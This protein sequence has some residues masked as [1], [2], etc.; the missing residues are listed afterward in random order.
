MKDRDYEMLD[1]KVMRIGEQI[2]SKCPDTPVNL[3][4]TVRPKSMRVAIL[5]VAIMTVLLLCGFTFIKLISNYNSVY[6]NIADNQGRLTK[7][8]CTTEDKGITAKVISA[9]A[10]KDKIIIGIEYEGF[11][12][13]DYEW[14]ISDSRQFSLITEEGTFTSDGY[15]LIDNSFENKGNGK[16]IEYYE[17]NGELTKTQTVSVSI[18]QIRDVIGNW[19]MSFELPVHETYEYA[20]NKRVEHEGQIWIVDKIIVDALATKIEYRTHNMED[21][22]NVVEFSSDGEFKFEND[23]FTMSTSYNDI[24]I[25][26]NSYQTSFYA[27]PTKPNSK[28]TLNVRY[29]GYPKPV[30]SNF[31]IEIQ[32][33]E[34]MLT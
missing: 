11:N 24:K 8:L 1:Q 15:Q 31:N 2:T 16:Y 21:N 22:M 27:V 14:I 5:I 17:L 30:H 18:K 26:E 23:G 10:G 9:I 19:S 20:V 7:P 13:S 12:Q 3:P 28:V 29:L 33:S 34:E 32:L 25:D 6:L 4:Q